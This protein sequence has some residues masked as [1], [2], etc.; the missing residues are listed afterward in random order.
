MHANATHN[1][2]SLS[3]TW[4]TDWPDQTRTYVPKDI[5]NNTTFTIEDVGGHSRLIQKNSIDDLSPII[6]AHKYVKKATD[7][8]SNI[9]SGTSWFD[10][11]DVDERRFNKPELVSRLE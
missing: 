11:R 2:S 10:F 4:M 9:G 5:N 8:A 6:P 1:K 7:D 3:Q